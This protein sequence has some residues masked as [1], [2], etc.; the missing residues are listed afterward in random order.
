MKGAFHLINIPISFNYCGKSGFQLVFA[1]LNSLLQPV[2]AGNIRPAVLPVER[3]VKMRLGKHI[4]V[5]GAGVIGL[6]IAVKLRRRGYRVTLIDPQEA[7]S[8]TSAGNAGLIMTAHISPLAIPGFWRKIPGMLSNP[9]G[10]VSIRWQHLPAMMPWFRQFLR[11][12][13][14]SRFQNIT[15]TLA[16]LS[17]RSFDA[18]TALLGAAE[19]P[20]VLRQDGVL[21]MFKDRRNFRAAQK[22]AAFRAQYG[23]TSEIIQPEELRQMEP[24]LGP[25]LAGGILYPDTGHC[26][27]PKAVSAS[28]SGAYRTSGGE[29]MRA[30][31]KQL[32][33]AQH[34]MVCVTT[35]HGEIIVDE[36]IVAAG[37]TSPD[38][39]KPFGV[40]NAL[41]AE[42]GYHLMLKNPGISLRRPIVAGDDRF[43]ITPMKDGLRL[44]GTAEFAHRDAEPDWRRSDMLLGQ[45][46]KLLPELNGADTATRWMGTRSSTPDSLPVIG[47]TPK[48]ARIICAYGHCHLGLTLGAV[49]AEL[50][51]G[52]VAGREGDAALAPLAP[53]RF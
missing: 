36:A 44:A 27:D 19:G 9:E 6:A 11:N 28:L 8:Q 24:A 25:D 14:K 4:A 16:P 33:S 48:N 7:G 52:L 2:L 45:A 26:I 50:V 34:N 29:V 21:Y 20:R 22:E 39:V 53:G 40:K 41:I 10:P 3:R 31:V 23:V 17:M 32:G 13:R 1:R 30:E 37:I 12:S 49:T 42:R 43:V 46:Q 35:D 15:G 5:I 51:E 18:W 38:L 47:R